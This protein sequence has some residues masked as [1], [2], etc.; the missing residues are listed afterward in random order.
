MR[1]DKCLVGRSASLQRLWIVALS[2]Y[3][4]RR[5]RKVV[6]KW[7]R[8]KVWNLGLVIPHPQLDGFARMRP[9]DEACGLLCRENPSLQS[10]AAPGV[11][12][13]RVLVA[14]L[15]SAKV[16]FCVHMPFDGVQ[17]PPSECRAQERDG[18]VLVLVVDAAQRRRIA[19]LPEQ[20]SDVMEKRR[21]DQIIVRAGLLCKIR[22]LQRVFKLRNRLTAVLHGPMAREQQ[23]NVVECARHVPASQAPL[24]TEDLRAV[25]FV[26]GA[27]LGPARVFS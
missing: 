10:K 22:R 7:W 6:G 18:E 2:H 4:P 12:R 11:V 1:T 5:T 23:R 21:R 13:E 27:T 16:A 19:L 25:L 20:V 3:A 15:D 14:W 8:A 17:H 24:G 9:R 26:A